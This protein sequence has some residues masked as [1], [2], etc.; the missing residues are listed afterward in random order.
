MFFQVFELIKKHSQAKS[1]GTCDYPI[2]LKGWGLNYLPKFFGFGG[3]WV[4]MFLEK[5]KECLFGAGAQGAMIGKCLEKVNEY[6]RI[7]REY[8]QRLWVE[9]FQAGNG[10]V[11]NSCSFINHFPQVFAKSG[12]KPVIFGKRFDWLKQVSVSA[13][14]MAE[15]QG[16]EG[17]R[18]CF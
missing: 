15:R 8:L 9:F 13:Q 1:S 14:E 6:L 2:W 18:F 3:I 12:E 17:I 7:Q 5:H 4:A 16:I 11:Y 10:L